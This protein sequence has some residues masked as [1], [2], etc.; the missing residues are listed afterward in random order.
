MSHPAMIECT[1][2]FT[3]QGRNHRAKTIPETL[4][5]IGR[6]PRVSRLLAL[7]HRFDGYLREGV[8]GSQAEL[9][10]LGHVSAARIAQIMNLLNLA[11]DIQETILFLSPMNKRG[12]VTLQDLQPIASILDWSIQR[13]M[14]KSVHFDGLRQ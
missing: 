10:V 14:W 5:P 7:A 13:A 12:V 6:L 4:P 1:V 8:A 3:R 2:R 11:P 9:A